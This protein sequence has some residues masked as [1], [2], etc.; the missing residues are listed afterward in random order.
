MGMG[1]AAITNTGPSSIT[2]NIGVSPAGASSI[3]GFALVLDGSGQFSRSAQVI[4]E[5]FAADYAPPTPANMTQAVLDMEAAYTDAQGRI[6]T[7][8][9]FN[10][11]NLGGQTLAPGVYKCTTGTEIRSRPQRLPL[12]ISIPC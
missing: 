12:V 9:N 7:S 10:A 6:P 1:K 5:V 2:G 11:G 4:G 3:T 8:T